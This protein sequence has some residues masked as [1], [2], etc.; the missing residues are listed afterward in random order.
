MDDAFKHFKTHPAILESD[1]PYLAKDGTCQENGKT[2]Q[3]RVTGFTDVPEKDQ[4]QLV[5]ALQ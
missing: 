5:A 3:V 4:D 2:G 1:Y